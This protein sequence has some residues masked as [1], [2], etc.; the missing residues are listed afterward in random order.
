MTLWRCSDGEASVA[1]QGLRG[2][3]VGLHL[4][5]VV[6]DEKELSRAGVRVVV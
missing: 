6:V 2:A 4:P 5:V 3:V 1:G